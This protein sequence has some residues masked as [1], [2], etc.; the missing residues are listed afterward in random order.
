MGVDTCLLLL[1]PAEDGH[2][3]AHA[4]SGLL[5]FRHEMQTGQV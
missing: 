3:P 4:C 1:Q 2:L 5:A